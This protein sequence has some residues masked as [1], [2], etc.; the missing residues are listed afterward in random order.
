MCAIISFC[1]LA[2]KFICVVQ[3]LLFIAIIMY[4]CRSYQF[5]CNWNLSKKI[6]YNVNVVPSSHPILITFCKIHKYKIRAAFV[7]SFWTILRSH[8]FRWICVQCT[9]HFSF[10][11]P[12]NKQKIQFEYIW[13]FVS[14]EPSQLK[15][16]IG[17]ENLSS[18]PTHISIE[19]VKIKF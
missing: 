18:R 7:H 4:Y 3:L 15:S 17:N 12:T 14:K 11:R 16:K 6:K 9:K 2:T 8:Q 1:I 10:Q 5:V 13:V 19:I